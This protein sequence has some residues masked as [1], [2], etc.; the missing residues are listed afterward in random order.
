[1][2]AFAVCAL[3]LIA[4]A[5]S[6]MASFPTF[7]ARSRVFARSRTVTVFLTAKTA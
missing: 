7:H 3:L 1:M 2:S 5:G 4:A 6:F